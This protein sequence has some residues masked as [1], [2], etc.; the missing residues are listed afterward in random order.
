MRAELVERFTARSRAQREQ[1]ILAIAEDFLTR[2]GCAAFSLDEVAVALGIA[3]GTIYTHFR[4][5]AE[6]IRRAL[7]QARERALVLLNRHL[8]EGLA[9]D[10]TRAYVSESL[11]ECA[12]GP[13]VPGRWSLPYPCCLRQTS[14]PFADV[15]EVRSVIAK[16]LLEA[17]GRGPM[18][19]EWWPEVVSHHVRA[20]LA[21]SLTRV[22]VEDRPTILREVEAALRLIAQGLDL[23]NQLEDGAEPGAY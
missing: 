19:A 4:S 21:S 6:L 3:K 7:E 12:P 18:D 23:P 9:L 16:A 13:D 8:R 10:A 14:C 22:C 2:K 5:R 17:R 20:V 1:E 15:D 11:E